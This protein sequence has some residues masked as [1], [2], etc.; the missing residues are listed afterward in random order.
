[1]LQRLASTQSTY[2]DKVVCV[3]K[4]DR[5]GYESYRLFRSEGMWMVRPGWKSEAAED[6][7]DKMSL[8]KHLPTIDDLS[9]IPFQGP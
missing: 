3:M 2:Q 7:E 1:M 4:V 5:E 8:L 6:D 9:A